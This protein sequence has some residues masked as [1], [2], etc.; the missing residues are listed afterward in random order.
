M[1][2]LKDAVLRN[3]ADLG[4]IFDTDVDRAAIVDNSGREINK[5]A[6]IALISAIVL[7]EH[8]GSTI[9]TDSVTSTGLSDFIS[10]I[11]GVH[12][13]YKRGYKNVINEAIRLNKSNE[14]SYLAIETSGHAAL[15]ENYFLDDGAYLISKIL[16]KMAKLN[17]E[18]KKV[19]DL[20]K[21]LKEPA[22]SLSIRLKIY[23]EDY[24]KYGLDVIEKLKEYTETV[25]EF[26]LVK[27][28][29]E[30]VRVN[31]HNEKGS[32][33]FLLR[34]SLHEP[35][36]CLN[37]ESDTEGSAKVLLDKLSSFFYSYSDLEKY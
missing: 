25:S 22:E 17:R 9:V 29:Y 26:E 24:R 21:D 20:I 2:S 12:H 23:S 37:I 31:W 10:K 34:L 8:P 13:R 32:G 7:E 28:N 36:L 15:K 19:Q 3:D 6:L 35:L 27:N 16:V 5:N 11:G 4:I 14:E 33:W 30:G 1:N 18:G